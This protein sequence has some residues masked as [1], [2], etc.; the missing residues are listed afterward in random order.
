MIPLTDRWRIVFSCLVLISC[1][2][3]LPMSAPPLRQRP[4]AT[5]RDP[6]ELRVHELVNAHRTAVGLAPLNYST[7]VTEIARRHSEDMAAGRV[8][9]GHEGL[10]ARAREVAQAIGLS[11]LAE[12]VCF[13]D[14]AEGATARTAVA[15]WLGSAGHRKNLEGDYDLT[16]VG[17]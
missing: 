8:P 6:L 11:G 1:A 9:L 13:N 12:N 14:D 16:G 15:W 7:R 4:A 17:I 5:G 2:A 10:Q 3:P